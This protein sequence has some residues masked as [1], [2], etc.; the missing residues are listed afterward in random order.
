MHS[1]GFGTHTAELERGEISGTVVQAKNN[2]R[3]WWIIY[4]G[5]S[6]QT[7]GAGVKKKGSGGESLGSRQQRKC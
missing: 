4:E 6:S 5:K 3:S 2:S 7:S 1:C